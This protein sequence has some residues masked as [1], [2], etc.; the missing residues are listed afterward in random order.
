MAFLVQLQEKISK[1]SYAK[2]ALHIVWQSSKK[3]TVINLILNLFQGINPLI[4]LYL[5]KKIIDDLTITLESNQQNNLDFNS[6]LGL[7]ILIGLVSLMDNFCSVIATLIRE[8]QSQIIT[9][10]VQNMLH[11]KSIEVDLEYYEN[12]QYYDALHQVQTEAPIRP[13][14]IFNTLTQFIQ[15]L[16]SLIAI[17]FL[18]LSLHW[19][20]ILILLSAALPTLVVKLKYADKIYHQWRRWTPKERMAYY[21]H[22]LLT[23]ATHAKEIRLFNLGFRFQQQY[24]Q[25]RREIRNSRFRL[26][27]GR[28]MGELITQSSA[29]ITVF[30]ATAIIAWQCW[31]GQISIGSLVMYYQAFQRGLS[32]VKDILASLAGLYENSLFLNNLSEFLALKPLIHSAKVP[33]NIPHFLQIG[34]KFE[35]VYFQYPH[36]PK[37]ILQ[38]VNLEIKVGETV[39][40]VGE[41]GA[42]KSSLIKLLCRLYDP[43]SGHIYLDH[44]NLKE[45]DLMQLRQNISAVFQDYAHYNL[46]VRENIGFGNL[47]Y[48]NDVQKI[49]QAA[50]FSGADQIINNLTSGY[51]SILGNE[52]AQGTELS[53]GEWQKIAIARAYLRESPIIILDEPTSALDPQAEAEILTKFAQLTRNRTSIIITHRL[54]SLKFVDRILVLAKGVIT[55]QGN[56]QEL[57]KLN[58]IYAHLFQTQAQF[59]A[60]N[61]N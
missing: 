34:I 50:Q 4:S 8:A 7:I 41:N 40:L 32:L 36:C 15:S 58:G 2:I 37:T 13:T 1:L 25:L 56:H 43:S 33:K 17:T 35:Q 38:G 18:L 45:F 51:D 47:D 49:A 6:I 21:L 42:G 5:L 29:T 24:N 44:I 28:T 61:H 55:E 16:I 53:V 3:Y 39:A 57:M 31:R 59:Y 26:A 52:F 19:S 20:V 23:Q 48:L 14:L 30:M 27:Q 54:S 9:D 12:H 46:T 10:Y 60:Q 22:N 11:Q